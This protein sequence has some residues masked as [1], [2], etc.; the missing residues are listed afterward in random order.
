MSWLVSDM[1]VQTGTARY[2]SIE[3]SWDVPVRN[4]EWEVIYLLCETAVS[5]P[6]C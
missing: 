4:V 6:D 3:I 1:K 5:R 2:L